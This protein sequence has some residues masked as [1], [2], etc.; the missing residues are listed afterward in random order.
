[1]AL[2][3]LA[4]LARLRIFRGIVFVRRQM[5][6]VDGLCRSCCFGQ[7]LSMMF[8]ASRE[9]VVNDDAGARRRIELFAIP[10]ECLHIIVDVRNSCG[11]EQPSYLR[12]SRRAGR[13]VGLPPPLSEI[14]PSLVPHAS[15]CLSH[16]PCACTDINGVKFGTMHAGFYGFMSRAMI[17]CG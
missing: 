14:D 10:P 9:P 3:A 12:N 13:E 6:L 8:T 16:I 5:L 11:I 17:E 7:S 2:G 4:G 1:M 15:L